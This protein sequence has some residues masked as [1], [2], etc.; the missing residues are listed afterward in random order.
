MKTDMMLQIEHLQKRFGSV[1][2]VEDVSLR[3]K[4]AESFGFVGPNRVGKTTTMSMILGL[5]SPTLGEVR[6]FSQPISPVHTSLK[7]VHS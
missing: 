1:H 5:M 7:A 4:Q 6:V 3:V 2:E